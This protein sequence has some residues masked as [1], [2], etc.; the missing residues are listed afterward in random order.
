MCLKAEGFVDRVMQ[1]GPSYYFQD[2]PSFILAHKLKAL[3]A[4]LKI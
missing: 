3:K 1:W 4:D 2:S